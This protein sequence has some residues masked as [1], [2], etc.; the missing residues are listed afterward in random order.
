MASTQPY[1]HFIGADH[2]M[3]PFYSRR[4]FLSWP[5]ITYF[6]A[7]NVLMAAS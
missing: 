5:A 6:P 2:V 4:T 3:F 1:T 7:A